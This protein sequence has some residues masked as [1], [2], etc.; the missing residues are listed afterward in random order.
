MALSRWSHSDHYIYEIGEN[1]NG[2]EMLQVCL[3]GYFTA[4]QILTDYD[5]IEK[6]AKNDGYGIFSRLELRAYL[7]SWAQFQYNRIERKT[8][9]NRLKWLRRFGAIRAYTQDPWYMEPKKI[10][11]YYFRRW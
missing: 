1:E 7:V 9:V 6:R 4:K 11:D 10:W 8:Y 3:F 2:E 5:S